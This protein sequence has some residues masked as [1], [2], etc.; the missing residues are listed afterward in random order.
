MDQIQ[1]F[2]YLFTTPIETTRKV[3]PEISLHAIVGGCPT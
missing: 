3:I 1:I 2:E